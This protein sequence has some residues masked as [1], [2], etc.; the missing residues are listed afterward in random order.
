MELIFDLA[1]VIVS[2]KMVHEFSVDIDL[3]DRTAP[4]LFVLKFFAIYQ[5]WLGVDGVSKLL[6][7]TKILTFDF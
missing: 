4:L 5:I 2:Q 3:D 6:N 7:F 1:I